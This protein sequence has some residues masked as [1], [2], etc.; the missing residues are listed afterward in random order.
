M[1]APRAR[2]HPRSILLI[3]L[4]R[5]GDVLLSTALLDDLRAAHPEAA[6][7]VLVGDTAAPLLEHHPLV[8]ER[9]VYDPKHAIRMALGIRRR[10]Y[11]WI[12]D[13]QSS[14]RTAHLVLVS[15]APVRVGWNITGWG[16]VYTHRLSRTG[17]P[18]EYVVRNRQ[19]LLEL[20]GVPPRAIRP[21]IEVTQEERA[22]AMKLLRDAG[23]PENVP[24]VG[25]VLAAG[26]WTKEWRVQGFA[27]L[28]D[29]LTADGM[30]PVLLEAPPDV[31]K[32]AEL[33]KHTSG[34]HV[35]PLPRI[36]D[37][38]AVVAACDVLVSGDTGPQ[39][40]ATALGVPTVTVF[41]PSRPVLW[42]ADVP[43]AVMIQAEGVGCLGCSLDEC[44][45]GHLCM[46]GVTAQRVMEEVLG[47][48][49]RRRRLPV[50]G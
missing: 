3:Q 30:A 38:L 27:E 21:R 11:D 34:G 32:V 44:S 31:P 17:H 43:D 33:R 20:V 28:V 4:R 25:L 16:W 15:G 2:P 39:H 14:P 9:I 26:N 49:G 7:D 35:V 36:R 19:R 42:R 48:L 5:L 1:N 8:R 18:L 47:Q 24:R 29:L 22:R 40:M 41:G 50:L 12:I 45:I 46:A 23:A 37:Y 10:R 6:L 13:A